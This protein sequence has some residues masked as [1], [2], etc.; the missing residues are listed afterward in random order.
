MPRWLR[1]FLHLTPIVALVSAVSIVGLLVFRAL[2]PLA[3]LHAAANE[4]GKGS[5]VALELHAPHHLFV[6][7]P[8]KPFHHSFVSET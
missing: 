2:A 7:C 4:L 3:D 1:T 8:E 6:G 5:G